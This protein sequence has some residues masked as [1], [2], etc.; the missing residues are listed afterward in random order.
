MRSISQTNFL[1]TWERGAECPLTG[2]YQNLAQFIRFEGCNLLGA[3]FVF[4]ACLRSR[5]D[6]YTNFSLTL[7]RKE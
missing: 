2:V 4:L 1:I 7:S 5:L 3:D 6:Q